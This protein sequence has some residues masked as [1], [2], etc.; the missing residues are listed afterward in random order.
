VRAALDDFRTEAATSGEE[1]RNDLLD[2]ADEVEK[3]LIEDG[4][5][6]ARQKARELERRVDEFIREGKIR[7]ADADRLRTAAEAIVDAFG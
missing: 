4:R 7:P 2:R 1:A 3:L 6:K 5:N